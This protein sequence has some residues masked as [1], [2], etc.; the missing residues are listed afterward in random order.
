MKVTFLGHVYEGEITTVEPKISGYFETFMKWADEVRTLGVRVN[1]DTPVDAETAKN[2]G[3]EGIGLCRTEHM[4][5]EEK[6]IFNF[7]KMI[8]ATTKEERE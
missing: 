2:F 1:A 4:F 5:F 6:R 3:A 8:V 7:R